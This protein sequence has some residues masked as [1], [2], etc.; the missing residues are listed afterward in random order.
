LIRTNRK[1][2]DAAAAF[3]GGALASVID[4]DAAHQ[5]RGHAEEMRAVLPPDVALVDQLDERL[6]DERRRLKRMLRALAPEI[7]GGH[8][9]QLAVHG[10]HQP[11]E[12][13]AVALAACGARGVSRGY[14]RRPGASGRSPIAA[15]R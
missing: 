6:V 2:I 9:P 5:L 13:R 12:R 8:P 11:I 1:V 3:A 15:C 4:E 14:R 7:P 10:R